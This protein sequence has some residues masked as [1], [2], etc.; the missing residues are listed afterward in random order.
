[1]SQP[2]RD[3]P[4]DPEPVRKDSGTAAAGRELPPDDRGGFRDTAPNPH[5]EEGAPQTAART[6]AAITGMFLPA[7]IVAIVA[8]VII[9]Y[10][11]LR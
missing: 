9:L 7:V 1:M 2:Q 11:V 5:D 8:I 6:T 3:H 10:F 4:F